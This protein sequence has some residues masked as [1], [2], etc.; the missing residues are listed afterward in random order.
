MIDIQTTGAGS[1]QDR[2]HAS[3]WMAQISDRI[4]GLKSSLRQI[5][6]DIHDH[7]EVRNQE[8]RAHKTL[9]NYMRTQPRQIW[10]VTPSTYGIGTAFVAVFDSGRPGP[11]VSFNAEYGKPL[12]TRAGIWSGIGSMNVTDIETQMR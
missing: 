12:C 7:P 5:S 11:T 3:G 2:D 1:T 4:D 10:E 6:L 9:T 8:H